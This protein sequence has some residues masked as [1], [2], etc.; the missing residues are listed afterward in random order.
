M[1]NVTV[2]WYI[3]HVYTLYYEDGEIK[4]DEA[5]DTCSTHGR[6]AKCIHVCWKT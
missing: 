2:K 1:S 6:D 3:F 5:E 4:E